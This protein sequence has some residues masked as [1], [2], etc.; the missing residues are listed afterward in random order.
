MLDRTGLLTLSEI[1]EYIN[2]PIGH[3][4]FIS[5]FLSDNVNDTSIDLRLGHRVLVPDQTRV[6]SFDIFD[7][8]QLT[9][10]IEQTNY[11][12]L[13]IQYGKGFNLH[14][15]QSILVGTLEYIGMPNDL[16]GYITLR[17]SLSRLPILANTAT[18]HPCY[19]GVITL[20]FTSMA[21]SPI[22]LRPGLRVAQMHLHKLSTSNFRE[23]ES[24]YD[25]AVG[26]APSKLSMD[27]DLKFIGPLNDPFIIGLVST[28]G[29][30]RTTAVKYFQERHGFEVFSLA[31]V[32][33][34]EANKQGLPTTR[35]QLQVLGT[36][37][38]VNNHSGYLAQALIQSRR[39]LTNKN[40]YVLADGF[41][42]P[43][44]VEEFRK[45]QRKFTLLAIDAPL[46]IR[47]KRV[48]NLRRTGD[49][50]TYEQ[51][52]ELDAVDRGISTNSTENG[53]QVEKVLQMAN[54]IINN[55]KSQDEFFANLETLLQKVLYS[56]DLV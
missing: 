28:L 53:Q 9:E 14:P 35:D 5:P 41:K 2:K 10:K 18:I 37:L 3:G 22:V 40:P 42:H 8:D 46:E 52:K 45:K 36:R 4:L 23:S 16:E 25:L 48:R 47:W 20:S 49:P 11:R 39:W 38:R 56:T 13:F 30:G 17:S 6:G 50:T 29:A 32:I 24:R 15:G 26:P 43:E 51:F 12:E 34:N 44:E 21:S 1:N 27:P 33:K 55:E 19:R 7:Q 54:H 31:E